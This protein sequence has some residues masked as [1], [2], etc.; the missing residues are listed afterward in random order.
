MYSSWDVTA[1]ITWDREFSIVKSGGLKYMNLQKGIKLDFICMNM[2]LMKNKKN[3]CSKIVH[4]GY[5]FPKLQPFLRPG[6][7]RVMSLLHVNSLW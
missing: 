4:E 3:I 6:S 5:L 1:E 2:K 7:A